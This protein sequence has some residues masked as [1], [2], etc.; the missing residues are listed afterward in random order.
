MP[1]HNRRAGGLLALVLTISL[2]IGSAGPGLGVPPPPPPPPTTTTTTTTSAWISLDG[3]PVAEIRVAIGAQKPAAMA[4]R[5][6][7]ELTAVAENP[8]LSPE[9]LVVREDPPYSM[10]GF[11]EADGAFTPK[12]AVDDRAG[13]AFGMSRQ[14]LA[15]RYRD[16]IGAALRAYRRDHSLGAWLKG[17]ALALLVLGIY[18]LWLRWQLA[19]NR[20]LSAW[21][22]QRSPLL[23]SR[24]RIGGSQLLDESQ[25]A[26][27]L[28]LLRRL[29]HWALL[30]LVS[31]LLIPL[32]LGF[33]PPTQAIAAGLR[34]QI[35]AVLTALASGLVG[36]IPN[37]LTIG[38]ILTITVL[39]MRGSHAWFQALER[40]RLRI[41]GFYREWAL[42]TDRIV[43][44]LILL[45]GLVIAYPYL[46]GSG[47][48]AF[49]GVGLFV[50][51]LAALGSSAVATNIISGLMLIYTRAFREGDRVEINGV[52]GVVQDQALLVTRIQT[53]RNELVSIPNAT[54]IGASIVNFSFSRREIQQPVALAT[55]IT[56]G[57]DVPWR[58]VHELMLGATRSVAGL[59]HEPEPYVLQTSLNDFHISYELNAYVRDVDRYRTTLSDLLAAIQDQFAAA[60]VEILSPGYH[61]IRNGNRS[62]VPQVAGGGPS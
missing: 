53:P 9:R 27:L 33:F 13:R 51:L 42:P 49:Q 16:Q 59:M 62:T 56:I 14:A 11:L 1:L 23:L 15:E 36:V 47:S 41:P 6:S 45:A 21:I 58:Q 17:T 30:L 26:A 31:Y 7:A 19:L 38:L 48:Q 5:V 28:Q 2:L 43:T 20:W 35:L 34:A 61:A 46:P 50:G 25:V 10:L 3:R 39:V 40:G 55:T 29:L 37:L 54:V 22:R 24:L 60:G 12:L 32:L 8:T 18:I 4:R 52:I 57:Y 44:L